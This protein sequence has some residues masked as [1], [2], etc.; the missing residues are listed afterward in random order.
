[1]ANVYIVDGART[2]FT[3]FGGSFA[4]V[5]ASELGKFT[6]IEAMKRANVSSE[7]IDHVI[8][9]NVIH[10][11]E[12]AAYLARHIGLKT[13][14]PNDVPALTLNRLCGSGAQSVVTAA[15]TILLEEASIVLAGGAENMS[16]SPFANFTQRFQPQKMGDVRYVDMLSAT[17]TDNYIGTGMG[18]TA[19]KLAEQYDISR[20]EQDSFAMESHKRAHHA[21][22]AGVFAEEIVPIEIAT[23]R[24][25]VTIER[26]EHIRQ[27]VRK[28]AM[29]KLRPA[30]KRDGTVTAGNASGIND[31][32][33]S[34]IVASEEAVLQNKLKPLSRIVS[35]GIVGVDPSVMGIGPVPAIKQALKRAELTIDD[36]DLFEINEAFASQYLA[37]ERELNLDREKTNVH[38]GA[39]ALGHPV[40]V[41]G[42]RLLLTLSYELRRRNGKYGIASLCIGGGQG[43]AVVIE[44]V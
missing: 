7:Q 18:L 38:G 17:L 43:I 9:G 20:K 23:K 2:A 42:T 26:D 40:G 33:A 19:E 29:E 12:N 36:I 37:V 39:I 8:Y 24:G 13:G 1:M 21:Q 5:D 30:F 16:M 14:V 32:A 44:N 22:E 28:D 3:E 4:T 10:T 34:L 35:W 25:V 15:Q 11:S 6:A 27:D 31:G 41:S